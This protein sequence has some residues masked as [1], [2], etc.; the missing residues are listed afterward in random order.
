MSKKFAN[1]IFIAVFMLIISVTVRAETFYAYLSSAQEVPINA[2]AATGYARIVVN[3]SALTINYTIVFN[4]LQG[5]QSGAHIHAPA[6]IGANAGVVI[7][8]PNP[9]GTSGSV[10]LSDLGSI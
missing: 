5:A 10:T 9:G 7:P 6:A 1:L 4:N 3:E 2:S 8:F